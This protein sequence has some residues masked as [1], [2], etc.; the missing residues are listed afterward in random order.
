MVDTSVKVVLEMFFLIFINNNILFLNQNLI[1]KFYIIAKA[2]LIIKR[3]EL[4]NEKKFAKTALDEE[5]N[6]F[7]MHVIALKALLAKIII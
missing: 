6:I 4:I 1:E 7:I 5:L 2:L 3:M